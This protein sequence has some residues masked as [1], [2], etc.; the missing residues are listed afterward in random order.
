MNGVGSMSYKDPYSGGERQEAIQKRMTWQ[1]WL[2]PA[3][4][5]AVS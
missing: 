5:G 1:A 2:S 4:V 3:Q